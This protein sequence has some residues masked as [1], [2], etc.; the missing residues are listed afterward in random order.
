MA[1]SE[2]TAKAT[3]ARHERRDLS[4]RNIAVFAVSLAVTVILVGWIC[5]ELFGHFLSVER[6]TQ[7][8]PSPLSLSPRP[9]PGP[10]LVVDPGQ[11][12]QELRASEDAILNTYGWIDRGKGIVRIPIDRAIELVAQKGLPTRAQNRTKSN[13]AKENSKGNQG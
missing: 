4:P 12:M 7:A 8:P 2:A 13:G 10:R 11:D 3:E 6:E 5:Y 1:E 9:V